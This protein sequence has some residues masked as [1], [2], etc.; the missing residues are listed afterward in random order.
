[1]RVD[2]WSEDAETAFANGNGYFQWWD[3]AKTGILIAGVAA[4][5]L[6]YQANERS[7]R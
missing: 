3:R 2:G 7:K 5:F 1:M 4:A 6:A